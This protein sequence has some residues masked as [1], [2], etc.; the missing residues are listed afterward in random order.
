MESSARCSASVSDWSGVCGETATSVAPAARMSGKRGLEGRQ[1]QVAVRAPGA[2][3]EHEDDGAVVRAARRARP[4]RRA[5]RA[6]RSAAP[7]A[8]AP[9]SGERARRAGR[10]GVPVEVADVSSPSWATRPARISTV[11]GVR[12]VEGWVGGH[13]GT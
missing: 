3:V 13:V 9:A 11:A 10:L 5:R 7:V 8:D 2:A 6:A 4:H 1:L 12:E